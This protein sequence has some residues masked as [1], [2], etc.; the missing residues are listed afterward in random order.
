MEAGSVRAEGD[1]ARW[2]SQ[3]ARIDTLAAGGSVD[4]KLA[5]ETRDML[6]AA[7]ASRGEARAKIESA[8]AALAER[9]ADL[10]KAKA[11]EASAQA[12]LQSARA[13]LARQKA[14]L[15]YTHLRAPYAGVVTERNVVRGDFVQSAGSNTARPLVSVARTDLVRVFVDVPEMDSPS[16]EAGRAG[17]VHVQ[18]LP[19]RTVEGKV[20][21]TSWLLGPN[22]TLRTELD[23]PNP[24][25]LLRPGMYATAHIVL[26]ERRDVLVLPLSAV[27]KDGQRTYC[28]CV[29]GGRIARKPIALGL[30]TPQE[31]EVISGL[32]GKENV[33]QSQAASLRDGQPVEAV[34]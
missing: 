12:R 5:D 19:G 14:L 2:K 7:E 29:E 24:N 33:V 26:E 8:K 11:D 16:V 32:D 31:A 6:K 23:L 4:R 22:R 17:Y 25:G 10:V 34:P 13:D 3:S 9:K 1:Y 21:R 15:E 27:V 28:C 20:A 30:Q 18:A